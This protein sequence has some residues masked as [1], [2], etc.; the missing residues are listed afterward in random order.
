MG[1]RISTRDDDRAIVLRKGKNGKDGS[2]DFSPSPGKRECQTSHLT[3]AFLVASLV[4]WKPSRKAFHSILASIVH[5]GFDWTV[6][7]GLMHGVA[8]PS[9]G[10]AAMWLGQL[11]I[12]V[13]SLI[14]H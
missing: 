3:Y 6:A 13:C 12:D 11:P 4:A 7:R 2:L 8:Q 9:S 10:N 1:I 5:R 14:H